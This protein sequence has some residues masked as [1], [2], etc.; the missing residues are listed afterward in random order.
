MTFHRHVYLAASMLT[1]CAVL[2]SGCDTKRQNLKR[3]VNFAKNRFEEI[4]KNAMATSAFESNADLG[5]TLASYIA[6][7]LPDNSDLPPFY[8]NVAEKPWSV[9][10]KQDLESAKISIEGYGDDTK[11]PML[12][13]EIELAKIQS[14]F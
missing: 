2:L 12:K 14:N 8:D 4:G 1:V 10:L 6:A 9:V 3:G 7:N 13:E 11:Q 5:G